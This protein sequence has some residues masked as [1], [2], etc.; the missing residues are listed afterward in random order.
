MRI[1]WTPVQVLFFSEEVTRLLAEEEKEMSGE[2]RFSEERK[3]WERQMYD[4]DNQYKSSK[5]GD[6]LTCLT[7]SVYIT[8][9]S[10]PCMS[11][12]APLN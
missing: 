9:Y 5:E 11:L 7:Y 8:C 1:F 6:D 10:L 12:H 3:E 4:V 2:T